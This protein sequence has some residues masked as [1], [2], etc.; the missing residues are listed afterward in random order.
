MYGASRHFRVTDKKFYN[1]PDALGVYV[2][3]DEQTRFIHRYPNSANFE[4]AV[5]FSMSI[6]G[7]PTFYYGMED[8]KNFIDEGDMHRR[9]MWNWSK[10]DTTT[11]FYHYISMMN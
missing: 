10:W 2:D 6:R 9:P 5:L 11:E 7:I 3:S 4:A 8:Y 1:D